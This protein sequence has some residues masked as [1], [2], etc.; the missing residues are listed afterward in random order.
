MI[1][2]LEGCSDPKGEKRAAGTPVR[3]HRPTGIAVA[4]LSPAPREW[5][6][7]LARGTTMPVAEDLSKISNAAVA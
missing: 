3:L 6:R 4:L 7:V 5:S 1:F 2:L